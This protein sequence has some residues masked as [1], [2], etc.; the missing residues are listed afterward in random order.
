MA[1][2]KRIEHTKRDSCH[3]TLSFA[4]I[5]PTKVRFQ[6]ILLKTPK[7]YNTITSNKKKKT[8]LFKVEASRNFF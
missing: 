3:K 4:K 8:F 1:A 6:S 2:E 7:L 5:L